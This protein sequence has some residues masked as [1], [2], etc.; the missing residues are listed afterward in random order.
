MSAPTAI[1]HENICGSIGVQLLLQLDYHGLLLTFIIKGN[2]KFQ[3]DVSRKCHFSHFQEP[4]SWSS[5]TPSEHTPDPAQLLLTPRLPQP[6]RIHTYLL[7]FIVLLSLLEGELPAGRV[8]LP[9]H[10]CTSR[11]CPRQALH[12][13]NAC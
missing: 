6:L 7:M 11:A 8:H 10:L 13:V 2:A 1:S 9:F 5:W 12:V 4:L 3:L